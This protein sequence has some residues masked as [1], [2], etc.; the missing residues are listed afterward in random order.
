MERPFFSIIIPT[1]N[2]PQV[3][4]M[5]LYALKHQTFRD[6]EV[7]LCDNTFTEADAKPVFQKYSDSRFK[8][9]K[10]PKELVMRDNWEYALAYA[11]G[12]YIGYTS[13]K[14]FF[15]QDA[16][17]LIHKAILEQTYPD[18]V[19]WYQDMSRI[20]E[21]Y[22]CRSGGY[23]E[24]KERIYQYKCMTSEDLIERKLSF[25]LYGEELFQPPGPGSPNCGV[26]KREVIEGIKKK[27]GRFFLTTDPDFG[28]CF[29]VLTESNA[30]IEMEDNMVCNIFVNDS[31]GANGST[32]YSCIHKYP[33]AV[34]WKYAAIPLYD[35]TCV[36]GVTAEYHYI[37]SL[38]NKYHGRNF[39]ELNTLIAIGRHKEMYDPSDC[40]PPEIERLFQE[41]LS[42]LSSE[43]RKKYDEIVARYPVLEG[44]GPIK[45]TYENKRMM[46]DKLEDFSQ[47][48]YYRFPWI[49]N[50]SVLELCKGKTVCCYGAGKYGNLV[51]EFLRQ[52]GVEVAGFL[53]SELS[54]QAKTVRDIPVY[55]VENAPFHKEETL[56]ILSLNVCFHKDVIRLLH[57]HG[58]Y[59][60][61]DKINYLNL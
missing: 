58:Y 15:Y 5:A 55:D 25:A 20:N 52:H 46:I 39:N 9:I 32:H 18:S 42:Q 1:H 59:H 34:S 30:H 28:P 43:E 41:A 33:A 10:P 16:L 44:K 22:D 48:I 47:A 54:D 57:A 13:D 56:I 60:I 24:R 17:E 27:Y 50:E 45:Y 61:Y 21:Q 40:P 35:V 3:V 53:V 14:I 31:A 49:D 12:R 2:R 51:L 38:N 8:Y 23:V 29:L 11:S 4:R 19:G 26:I 36:N 6:F 7:I 37:M